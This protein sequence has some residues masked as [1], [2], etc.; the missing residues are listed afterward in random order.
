MEH[1]LYPSIMD[2]VEVL[3]TLIQETQ[4]HSENSITVKVSQKTQKVEI[5]LEKEGSCLAFFNTDLGH[6]FGSNVGIEIGVMLRGEGPHKPE[7]AHGIVRN[8]LS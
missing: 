8:T 2:I 6:I 1:G 7:F 3:N 5:Y 4:T